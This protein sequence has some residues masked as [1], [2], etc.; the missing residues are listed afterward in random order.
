MIEHAPANRYRQMEVAAMTPA[1]LVVALS[2]RLVLSVKQARAAIVAGDVE[3]RQQRLDHACAILHELSVSLDHERG[4]EIAGRLAA[5][6]AWLIGECTA[7]HA[8]PSA[9]RLDASIKVVSEL[10]EAWVA[11]EQAAPG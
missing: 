4:G 2:S 10:H 8:R 7:V 3:A 5:L 9:E 6:Y 11:A 1:Q